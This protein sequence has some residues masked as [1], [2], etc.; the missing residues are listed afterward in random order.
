MKNE[1][2]LLYQEIIDFMLISGKRIRTLSGN[3]LDIG[4]KKQYLTTEDLNIERGL[5]KYH[6]E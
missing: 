6:I 3:I 1:M 2:T 4:I 5:K